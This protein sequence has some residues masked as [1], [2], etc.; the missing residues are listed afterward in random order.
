MYSVLL[1]LDWPLFFSDMVLW[2]RI[3]NH[4][5]NHGS[6]VVLVWS[7]VLITVPV[8]GPYELGKCELKC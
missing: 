3:A 6:L 4:F 2:N 5:T 1:I 8:R 7:P